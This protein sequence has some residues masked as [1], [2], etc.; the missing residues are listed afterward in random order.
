MF[1]R[2]ARIDRPSATPRPRQLFDQRA[3]KLRLFGLLLFALWYW[4]P[5][6][7]AFRSDDF[8]ALHYVQDWDRVWQDFVAPQYDALRVA[9]FHRPLITLSIAIDAWIGGNKP[10][11][12]LLANVLVHLL[13][14]LLAYRLLRRFLPATPAL[15]AVALWCLHP[16]HSEALQWMVGRVDTHATF[17][18]LLTLILYCRHIEGRCRLATVLLSF[19][20]GCLSKELCLTI[21][22]L[23][24]AMELGYGVHFDNRP[25]LT[26]GLA[27]LG[28]LWIWA[29]A[30]ALV[31]LMRYAVLGECL[32]GYQAAVFQPLAAFRVQ[33]LFLDF[34][35]PGVQIALVAPLLLLLLVAFTLRRK[36]GRTLFA[37]AIFFVV[38][39]PSTSAS[40]QDQ[41]SS[42]RYYYAPKL[43]IAGAT[44]LGGPLPPL[45]FLVT[46]LGPA[47][48]LHQE[49]LE[50]AAESRAV[51]ELARQAIA[52]SS[53]DP[54]LVPAPR[55]LSGRVLFAIGSDRLGVP[56]FSEEARIVLPCRDWKS[57]ILRNPPCLGEAEAFFDGPQSLDANALQAL[58]ADSQPMRLGLRDVHAATLQVTVA[59]IFGMLTLRFPCEQKAEISLRQL[60]TAVP[61]GIDKRQLFDLLWPATEIALDPRPWIYLEAF[62]AEGRSVAAGRQAIALPLQRDY[63][64]PAKDGQL[65]LPFTFLL[66]AAGLF[67]LR[68]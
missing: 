49:S 54:V 31:L 22:A 15:A 17:F 58:L 42:A 29:I 39:L 7:L 43:A 20:L 53:Q 33:G 11:W 41:R 63:G 10:F 23:I 24:F 65:W 46:Q 14:C 3:N 59:D 16:G 1:R 51:Q 47:S 56:P 40:S 32:G 19:F 45:F 30:L 48:K 37:V 55:G 44:A 52:S 50:L 18:Y 60:M 61:K 2:R 8:L 13:N 67:F 21:P 4:W 6:G 27:A 25:L 34:L 68:R 26:R 5:G 62:D 38:A 12:P 35:E 66:L 28:R 36:L 9:L 64:L 57:G